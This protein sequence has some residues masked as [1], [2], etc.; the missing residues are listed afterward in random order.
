MQAIRSYVQQA[1][2]EQLISEIGRGAAVIAD[3]VPEIH[4]KITDLKAS[5]ALQ[6]E[7]ARFR[8]FNS[9]STFL[10]NVSQSQPLMLVLDALHWA[11]QSSLR[12]LEFLAR[13]LGDSRFLLVGCYRDT[14]LSR[15]HTL[16]DTLARLSR[17]PVFSRQVLRGLGQDELGQLIEATTGVQLSQ[18]LTGTLYAHTEGNPF[19]MTEVIRLL[20]ESGKLT[21]EHIGTP[22]GV[23][24]P[25]SVR[26]VIGQR[27][28]RLSELCN[29]VLTTASII[30]R[31]F[32]LKLLS[33][34]IE[35]ITEDRVLEA[36]EEA[37]ASRI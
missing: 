33:N 3:V 5:P 13:E 1:S 36:V 12:L 8:L 11:D 29:Q 34:L 6:P 31:E 10:K 16:A 25:A 17:E 27:L 4:D 32:E 21:A 37:L 2:A 14:E 23:R 9:I 35:D 7:A 19:F 22:E 26:E 20:S 28:N 30:G 24:V 15:Q 18:E